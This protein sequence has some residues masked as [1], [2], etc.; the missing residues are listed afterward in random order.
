ML[1][2]PAYA[3]IFA[4]LFVALSLRTVRLRRRLRVAVGDGGD[5]QLQR[6]A[7]VHSNFAEYVPFALVLIY[8]TE[9]GA[10][11][12]AWVHGLCL[13]LLAGRLLHAY[14]VSQVKENYRF[15]VASMALTFI[16]ILSA[17]FLLLYAY[18]SP[19]LQY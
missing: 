8:F 5:A 10:A 7:R 11:G 4:L 3:A 6:A 17:A 2:T 13:A 14:G 18:A 16:V 19:Q 15:R 9:I 12:N 1:I